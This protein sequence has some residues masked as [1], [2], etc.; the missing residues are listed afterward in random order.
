[1][2]FCRECNKKVELCPHF[3]E[4]LKAQIVSVFDPKIESFAYSEEQCILQIAFKSGQVW[5]LFGIAPAI[6][7]ELRD[8]SIYS[9]LKVI[10][11]RYKAAPVKTGIHAIRVPESEPCHKC[12]KPMTVRHRINSAFDCNIRVLW[13]CVPCQSTQWRDY[14]QGIAREKRGK[15][16]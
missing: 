11:H 14:G 6:Y 13:E 4:P 15:W 5:Q 16:H 1:M 10:A 12:Q 3:V 7:A 9:F 2:V 8:T